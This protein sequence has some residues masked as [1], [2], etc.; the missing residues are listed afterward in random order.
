MIRYEYDFAKTKAEIDA[1]DPKWF[2]KATKRSSGFVKA[3]KFGEK[4]SIWSTVKPAFMRLQMNKCVFCERQFENPEYG[5]IEFDLEHFRPKSSVVEW[6][7]AV[8]HSKLSYAFPTGAPSATGYYWL[9]YDISNYAA[10]CKVCNTTF[11]SNY[12]PVSNARGMAPGDDLSAEGAHLCY[13]IG[14][15]DEDPEN[16]ISFLATTA[17][18]ANGSPYHRQRGQVIID[19]FGLNQREQLH[20]ERAR[21]ISLFGSALES[22]N[23]GTATTDDLLLIERIM[24]PALP[25]A[26]CLRAFK[27]SWTT[28]PDLARR[29]YE[30]CRRYTVSDQGTA[31]PTV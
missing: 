23:R 13:P 7:H 27:N 15:S 10:S 21:M 12:F 9:S 28:D 31:P 22:Q 1:I 17:V 5:T 11:K 3:G 14:S 29:T 16:L 19:F 20:R 8:V 18:P 4:T 25:H 26:S 30:L 2:Q 6:P 24:S